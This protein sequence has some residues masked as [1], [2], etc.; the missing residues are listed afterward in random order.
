MSLEQ[1]CPDCG[2]REAA[3]G[4]CSRCFRAMTAADWRETARTD[5]Q[6]EA[7]RVN[8]HRRAERRSTSKKSA[9]PA[10][11]ERRS[12]DPEGSAA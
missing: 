8:A 5:A 1:V 7:S 9:N 4:M 2:R 12:R 3:G 10:T 6:V 11:V